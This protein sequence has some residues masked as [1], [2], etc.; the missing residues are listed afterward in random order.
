MAKFDQ[1]WSVRLHETLSSLYIDSL[2]GHEMDVRNLSFEADSFEVA[3]DKG[4]SY[5][6]PMPNISIS[7]PFG[8]NNGRHDDSQRGCLGECKIIFM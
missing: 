2:V 3:I 4:A 7:H 5:Y 6:N 8:R 1:R